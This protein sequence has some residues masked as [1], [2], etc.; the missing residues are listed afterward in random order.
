MVDRKQ[1]KRKR[2]EARYNLEKHA[3]SDPP[4]PGRPHCPKFPPPPKIVPSAGDQHSTHKPVETFHVQTRTIRIQPFT[5][6]RT[7]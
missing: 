1:R 4:P 2:L 5:V 6:P 7:Y 3:P